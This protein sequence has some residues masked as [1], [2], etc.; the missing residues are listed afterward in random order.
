MSKLIRQETTLKKIQLYQTRRYYLNALSLANEPLL[1]VRKLSRDLIAQL[2][3]QQWLGPSKVKSIKM[4][5]FIFIK[6]HTY[7][8][9]E[10][11][12]GK[13]CPQGAIRY[14]FQDNGGQ[15]VA[16]L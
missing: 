8:K 7:T 4:Y 15:D 13:L 11:E 14:Q 2:E 5:H 6:S 12:K 10:R 16:R 1:S 3:P 9:R